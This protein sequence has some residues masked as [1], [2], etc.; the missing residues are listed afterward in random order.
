[1]ICVPKTR[2][3]CIIVFFLAISVV[4]LGTSIE[5]YSI[6][7]KAYDSGIARSVQWVL[8]VR[9]YEIKKKARLG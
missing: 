7:T 2:L 6:D 1:M 9:Q 5:Y 8:R 4:I 3:I